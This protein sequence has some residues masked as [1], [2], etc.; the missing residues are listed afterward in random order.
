[1][2]LSNKKSGLNNCQIRRENFIGK[3][4]QSEVNKRQ[5]QANDISVVELSDRK[6]KTSSRRDGVPNNYDDSLIIDRGL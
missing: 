1:M 4:L 2:L 3:R 5:L 6:G